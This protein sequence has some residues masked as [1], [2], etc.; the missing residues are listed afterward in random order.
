MVVKPKMAQ[1]VELDEEPIDL[2][3]FTGWKVQKTFSLFLFLSLSL[4]LSVLE[5]LFNRSRLNL[6]RSRFGWDPV[7]GKLRSNGHLPTSRPPPQPIKPPTAS[8]VIFLYKKAQ[9][10]IISRA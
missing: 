9:I 8:L 7:K 3:N 2:F 5:C 1:P 4:S 10:F 6:N